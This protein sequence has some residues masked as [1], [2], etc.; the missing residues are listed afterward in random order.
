MRYTPILRHPQTF[1][2][3]CR[4]THTNPHRHIGAWTHPYEDTGVCIF[5]DRDTE[6]FTQTLKYG[7]LFIGRYMGFKHVLTSI[8]ML[9]ESHESTHRGIVVIKTHLHTHVPAYTCSLSA[10]DHHEN[11]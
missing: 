3:K 2:Q 8:F 11:I 5:I 7:D 1:M 10:R 6:T 4:Q 9:T